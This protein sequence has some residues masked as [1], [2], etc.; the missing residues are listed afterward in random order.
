M[1]D[2]L[3]VVTRLPE[4]AKLGVTPPEWHVPLVMQTMAT[5][6]GAACLAMVLAHYGREVRLDDIRRSMDVGRDG[7]S[8]RTII[9]AAA[10]WDLRGRGVRAEL[11]EL[12]A[13]GP[14][15]ILHWNFSHFVVFE[16][17]H[18]GAVEIVDPALG[19]RTVTLQEVSRA[20]TGVALVFDKTEKFVAQKAGTKPV[21]V[22]LKRAIRESKGLKKIFVMSLVLQ[23]LALVVPL[24]HGRIVDRVIPRNDQ[25]LL[26]VMLVGL[27]GIVVFGFV[28]T[29][30]RGQLLLHLRTHLDVRMTVGFLE[31]MLRLPYSFFQRRPSGDLLMRVNSNATIRE[32]LTSSMLSMMIDSILVLVYLVFLLGISRWM[33]IGTLAIVALETTVFL[34]TRNRQKD[35]ASGSLA[36]QAE[37]ESALVETLEAIETIKASGTEHR[38]LEQW[39]SK[40]VEVMNISLRRGALQSWSDAALHALKTSGPF[41]LLL[42]GTLQ[43]LAGD[44]SLGSML[45]AL[46]FATGF[47]GPLSQ[48]VGALSQ[49]QL[50][51]TYINRIDDVL[52]T[53]PEQIR[54]EVQPA[55][56]LRGEIALDRVSFRYSAKAPLAVRDVSLK[57]RAGEL[58]AI[59]GPSGSGKSTLTN[60]LLGMQKATAGRVLYDGHDLAHVDVRGVRRQL[61]IVVQRPHVFGSTVRANL[62]L[63]AP[64]APAEMIEQVARLA[65]VHDDIVAMPLGYDTPLTQGGASLSG[66]QRQRIALARALLRQPSILLLDEATSALDAMTEHRVHTNL[67]QIGCTRI[68][69]AHRLSTIARADRI[70]VMNGG[71]IV[72]MGKHTELLAKNGLYAR[73]FGA[74]LGNVEANPADPHV[75]PGAARA[76]DRTQGSGARQR[77][78]SSPPPLPQRNNPPPLPQRPAQQQQSRVSTPPPAVATHRRRTDGSLRSDASVTGPR[79]QSQPVPAHDPSHVARRQRDSERTIENMPQNVRRL[80]QARFAAQERN[81]K[82]HGSGR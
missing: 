56:H 17:V 8:A 7:V 12:D 30:I 64:D 58:V 70:I 63:G 34:V 25:S 4:L 76:S 2:A 1:S 35:L 53:A 45:S 73:L 11:N 71:Q 6:C 15:A 50:V 42:I 23:I 43:V 21:V 28:S 61:G 74:Q 16:R 24:V 77:P 68:V 82:R 36:K 13:L 3:S 60:L 29:L 20:F 40:Y 32:M 10:A 49:L 81:L 55:P 51:G 41:V 9:D 69:V 65:C 37:A 38:A 72:E 79:P 19:R 22:H 66:G 62:T 75:A 80:S 39:S 47:L 57:I 31:H 48:L 59:V 52:A 54:S 18:E 44:L 26:L 46:S 27:V 67:H 14:G 78:P 33:T 5:D